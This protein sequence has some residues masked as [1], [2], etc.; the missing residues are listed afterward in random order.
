MTLKYSGNIR[1]LCYPFI[2]EDSPL[3]DYEILTDELCTLLGGVITELEGDENFGDIYDF[4]TALQPRIFHMNGS[5]RGKQAIFEEQI[6]WVAEYFDRYQKEIEGQLKGFVLPRG[7]HA[8]QL[9]HMARS[10]S[11]KVVRAL[12]KVDAAGIDVPDELHR[13]GNMLCN[14]FFRLTVVINR[15]SGV[16]EPPYESLSYNLKP[17]K[18][19][20]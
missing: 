4:L 15:R 7:G 19:Y 1:E 8:V 3:C 16:V 12:V 5:I 10:L 11:K 14:L 9:L 13:M 17:S 6:E 2:Y 20:S 18:K